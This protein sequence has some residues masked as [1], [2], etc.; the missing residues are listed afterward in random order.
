M[1]RQLPRWKNI[2]PLLGWSLPKFPLQDRKLKNVVVLS[3]ESLNGYKFSNKAQESFSNKLNKLP[4]YYNHIKGTC[5]CY[6]CTCN[7]MCNCGFK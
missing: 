5:L 6:R 2:K 3:S 1:K 7:M 4:A